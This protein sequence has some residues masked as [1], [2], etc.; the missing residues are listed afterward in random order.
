MAPGGARATCFWTLAGDPDSDKSL[1]SGAASGVPG[2]VAGMRLAL[3]NT[4]R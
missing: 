3:E 2:T 4:A 1:Y